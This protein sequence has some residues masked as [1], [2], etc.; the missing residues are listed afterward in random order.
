M[1]K[2]LTIDL[3]G[4]PCSNRYTESFR[5]FRK[6]NGKFPVFKIED[7]MKL[8]LVGT[9]GIGAKSSLVLQ[10]TENTFSDSWDPT[11]EDTYRKQTV[12]DDHALQ[13]E[14]TDTAGAQEY[15]S[16]RPQYME[17]GYGFLL[18]YSITDRASFESLKEFHAEIL[19]IK[20][21]D[22]YPKVLVGNKCDLEVYRQVS[23]SEGL[24]LAKELS[25]SFFETSAKTRYNVEEA[26]EALVRETWDFSQD[27]SQFTKKAIK[28][29]KLEK[30][31][32]S[33][34]FDL[35]SPKRKINEK[36]PPSKNSSETIINFSLENDAAK[37]FSSYVSGFN[38]GNQF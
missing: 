28:S 15:A 25:C 16:M 26:V 34:L 38:K 9:G 4:N 19:K 14:F 20:Q 33:F 32:R 18:G 35:F 36:K 7:L 37:I 17:E 31:S 3:R 11:I 6:T 13:I 2:T 8:V 5:R 22:D 21:V 27:C 12:V 1:M 24:E 29:E 23:T 10:Y 30:K